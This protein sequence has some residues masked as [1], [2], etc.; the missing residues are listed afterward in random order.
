MP[1]QK[2]YACRTTV[3]A[4]LKAVWNNKR[5]ALAERLATCQT[6]TEAA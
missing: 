3:V 4:L 5:S 1:S 2:M 6:S